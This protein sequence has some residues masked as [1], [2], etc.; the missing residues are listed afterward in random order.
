MKFSNI[1]KYTTG[2]DDLVGCLGIPNARSFNVETL[3]ENEQDIELSGNL[4][5]RAL[6]IVAHY[7]TE[8][9]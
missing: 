4:T 6:K 2:A 9:P 8:P 7:G 1:P 3:L 5:E